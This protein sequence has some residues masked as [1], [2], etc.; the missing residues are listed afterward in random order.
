VKLSVGMFVET[1]VGRTPKFVF[2][3]ANPH[4]R[5]ATIWGAGVE[6]PD[7]GIS[8]PAFNPELLIFPP[9]LAF[10]AELTD[11]AGVAFMESIDYFLS[12]LRAKKVTPPVQVIGYVTDALGNRHESARVAF[13]IGDAG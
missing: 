9:R 7:C 3:V 10:P 4:Q 13:E 2:S 6:A 8:A 11:G 12:Q 1:D 5:P